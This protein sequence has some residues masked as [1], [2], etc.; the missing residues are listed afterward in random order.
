MENDKL[1]KDNSRLKSEK[2]VTV[3][4]ST[5]SYNYDDYLYSPY[6]MYPR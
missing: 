3:V 5:P 4:S 2:S 1:S 6:V